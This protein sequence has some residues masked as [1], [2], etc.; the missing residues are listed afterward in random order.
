[1][2]NLTIKHLIY[3]AYLTLSFSLL[4]INNDAPLW[5]IVLVV[6]N[7][8]NAARLAKQIPFKEV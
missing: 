2:K 7:F 6:I 4:S 5:A 8:M 3:I 1:M